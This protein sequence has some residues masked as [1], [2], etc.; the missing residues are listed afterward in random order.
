K[1]LLYL[2]ADASFI[3]KYTGMSALH[4]AVEHSRPVA[5][6]IL[7][8]ECGVSASVRE[9]NGMTALDLAA[10]SGRGDMIKVLLEGG[11]PVEPQNFEKSV[12]PLHYAARSGQA[13]CV[14]LLLTAKAT[15]G[16][17]WNES[18]R[19]T[20]LYLAASEGHSCVIEAL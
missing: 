17:C 6:N 8:N 15:A 4:V 5:A 19:V 1:V 3:S 12:T 10:A 11:V 13:D 18:G 16:H 9:K 7:L 14:R 2:G 20:P